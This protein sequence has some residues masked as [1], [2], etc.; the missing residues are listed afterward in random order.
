MYIYFR[1]GWCENAYDV[2][3][4]ENKHFLPQIFA[5][6]RIHVEYIHPVYDD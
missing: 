6:I 3:L 4:V 5:L 2:Q 1:I